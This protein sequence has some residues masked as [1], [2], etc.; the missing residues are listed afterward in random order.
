MDAVKL[1][2][3]DACFFRNN[4]EL[5]SHGSNL[6]DVHSLL[7]VYLDGIVV[8][9]VNKEMNTLTQSPTEH[10]RN[11]CFVHTTIRRRTTIY[12]FRFLEN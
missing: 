8:S 4:Y 7:S 11:Y 5:R 10:S 9:L 3:H 1:K 6:Y 12:I 2:T